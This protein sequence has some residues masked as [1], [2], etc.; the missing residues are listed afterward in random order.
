[1]HVGEHHREP[2]VL[3]RE[4]VATLERVPF[5]GRIGIVIAGAAASRCEG[6]ASGQGDRDRA[7]AIAIDIAAEQIEVA[8]RIEAEGG[9]SL[10]HYHVG[11][12]YEPGLPENV[13]DVVFCRLVLCHLRGSKTTG[14]GKPAT[15]GQWSRFALPLR[16][17]AC[18][19]VPPSVP[20]NRLS[21][22]RWP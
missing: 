2:S 13:Y 22:A 1:V 21:A 15:S 7:V 12:A 17:F 14:R 18:P 20:R 9:A 10:I 6:D 5:D 4:V 3:E 11:S 19:S 16:T 8:K